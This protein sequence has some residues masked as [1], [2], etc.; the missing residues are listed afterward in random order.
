MDDSYPQQS[1]VPVGVRINAHASARS[2]SG[3]PRGTLTPSWFGVYRLS[4]CARLHPSCCGIAC[5]SSM[6]CM[7]E[8]CWLGLKCSGPNP[9]ALLFFWDE[10]YYARSCLNCP[11]GMWLKRVC[12]Q[13]VSCSTSHE[14]ICQQLFYLDLNIPN[15]SSR[16][17]KGLQK[18]IPGIG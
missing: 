12:N 17:G 1:R 16:V 8:A 3:G 2:S 7:Y 11:L 18:L 15:P 9:I 4:T 6:K 13:L 10:L 14:F 5:Y